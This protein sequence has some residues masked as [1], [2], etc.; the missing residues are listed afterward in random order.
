M[1]KMLEGK[2]ICSESTFYKDSGISESQQVQGWKSDLKKPGVGARS[3]FFF[4]LTFMVLISEDSLR[5]KT[6]SAV[7]PLISTLN[8]QNTSLLVTQC[9]R[10]SPR[11][12]I[13]TH[14]LGILQLNSLLILSTWNQLWIP[15]VNGSV[16]LP[17]FQLLISN[18]GCYL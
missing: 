14:E 4:F 1:L 16:P 10:T 17:S 15:Q 5:G 12:A 11:Q 9:V 2:E 13:L 6:H 3:I 18:P 7:S 8:S